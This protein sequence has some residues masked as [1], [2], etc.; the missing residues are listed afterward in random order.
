MSSNNPKSSNLTYGST[1]SA[2]S[3]LK[4]PPAPFNKQSADIILRSA[5]GVDFRARKGVLI[6]AS[7]FFEDM[8]SLPQPTTD[9]RSESTT[10]NLQEYCDGIPVLPVAEASTI[11]ENLLRFCYPVANPQMKTA[12]EICGVL[13]ASRKYLMDDVEKDIVMQFNSHANRDPLVMYALGAQHKWKQ[14]MK[15]AAKASLWTPFP[16]GTFVPQMELISAGDYVRLQGY[17]KACSAAAADAVLK[18]ITTIQ[19]PN[20]AVNPVFTSWSSSAIRTANGVWFSCDHQLDTPPNGS[21]PFFSV[22]TTGVKLP[23]W[24]GSLN[25]T[26]LVAG[27]VIDLLK[28]LRSEVHLCP[29]GKTVINSPR[30]Q[31]AVATGMRN[32]A[33]C[34]VLVPSE[35]NGL[36]QALAREVESAV[37]K[38]S[39]DLKHD[40]HRDDKSFVEVELQIKY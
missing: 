10:T 33:T 36:C 5:D 4:T 37:S 9:A 28:A 2:T 30:V 14:E 34:A 27:W 12:A 19:N 20:I 29:R 40:N 24:L 22:S 7:A 13:E 38:V 26:R 6:E 23:L 15:T 3:H 31:E 32:C 1:T 16:L 17:H 21:S 18:E 39:L 8:I 35:V 25:S 11:V